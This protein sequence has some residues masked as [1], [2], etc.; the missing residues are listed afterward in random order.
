MR[1][2]LRLKVI[3]LPRIWGIPAKLTNPIGQMQIMLIF[4][5]RVPLSGKL[6]KSAE[7]NL[8]RGQRQS[9]RSPHFYTSTVKVS[10]PALDYFYK[11]SIEKMDIGTWPNSYSN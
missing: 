6:H 11:K 5:L 10:T 9:L 8:C 2:R 7:I 3:S 1:P 4:G